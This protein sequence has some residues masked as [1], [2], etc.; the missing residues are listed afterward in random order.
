MP[1]IPAFIARC[2]GAVAIGRGVGV[3]MTGVGLAVV[4]G[5]GAPRPESPTPDADAVAIVASTAPTTSEAAT[6]GSLSFRMIYP[7]EG[8]ATASAEAVVQAVVAGKASA[9]R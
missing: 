7:L 8:P 6:N 4:V 9:G 3:G 2:A 5:V 1:G